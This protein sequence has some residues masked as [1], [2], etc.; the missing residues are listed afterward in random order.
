[1]IINTIIYIILLNLSIG[2]ALTAQ[3]ELI[4]DM[5]DG[6]RAIPVHLIELIDHDSSVIRLDDHP[7][8]PFSTKI[9]CG[10]CHNY[11]KISTGWHFNAADTALAAGRPGHPWIYVDQ[12]TATQ[13]PLALRNWPGTYKPQEIGISTLRFLERF[14]RHMPGGG[15]GDN[16][17]FRSRENLFRWQVSGDLEINCLSCHEAEFAYDRSEYAVQVA[18]QNFRWAATAASAFAWVRGSAKDMPDN[19]D[20]YFGVAPDQPQKLPPQVFYDNSRFNYKN[21]VFFDIVKSI[22]NENCYFCHST[23]IIDSTRT[24][25][26]HFDSDVHVGSGMFCVDCHRHGLDHR[27]VRGYEGEDRELTTNIA[28]TLTCQGC[29]LGNECDTI[30]GD[31]RLGAPKPLHL[32]IPSVHF[33]KLACTSCH[34]GEWP[35]EQVHNVRTS[36]AHALGMHGVNKS[37]QAL[38][39]ISAPVFVKQTDGKIAP[40]NLIWPS[41]WAVSMNDSIVPLKLDVIKPITQAYIINDD[42]LGTGNWLFLEDGIVYEILDS[43]TAN[44]DSEAEAVFISGGYLFSRGNDSTLLKVTHEVAEPYVWPVAHDVRPAQQSLGIRGCSDCHSTSSP[45]YFATLNTDSPLKQQIYESK[46]AIDFQEKNIIAAWVFSFSFLF[47]PWLKLF[48][49][50]SCL[51]IVGVLILY[52]FKGL[53]IITQAAAGEE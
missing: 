21:E 25:R 49:I 51:I 8:M 29:H 53:A 39:H 12:N 26:W 38:P 22:P 2:F 52:A 28:A 5:S 11:S 24:Q 14:G 4:G 13:I 47:R 31:G 19:Y 30:P 23:H 35:R 48:I 37:V 42:T 3:E 15:I 27:M 36:A 33:E 10:K 41:F 40:H 20:I 44:L 45:F 46:R 6:S 18:R 17:Q 16:E 1:V 43:L 34:S 7:L 50:I 9:T 32:G